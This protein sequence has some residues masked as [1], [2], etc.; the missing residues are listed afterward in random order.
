[1]V[2]M[3]T[4]SRFGCRL[5]ARASN[6]YYWLRY[7]HFIF[8]SGCVFSLRNKYVATLILSLSF[9]TSIEWRDA[10]QYSLFQDSSRRKKTDLF[11]IYVMQCVRFRFFSL[12]CW[13]ACVRDGSWLRFVFSLL[14]VCLFMWSELKEFRW[15]WIHISILIIK[16]KLMKH[17]IRAHR[18]TNARLPFCLWPPFSK[19]RFRRFFCFREWKILFVQ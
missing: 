13:C 2:C 11:F 8:W 17:P 10:L 1:M 5:V 3:Q 4:H 14:F 6:V 19:I 7:I 16:H 12:V 15:C 9:Y 18:H